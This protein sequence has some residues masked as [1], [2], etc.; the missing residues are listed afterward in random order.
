MPKRP[1]LTEFFAGALA[2]SMCESCEEPIPS[3]SLIDRR[4]ERPASES[5]GGPRGPDGETDTA[6]AEREMAAR[7]AGA[8]A[9]LELDRS[10]PPALV[11]FDKTKA[12]FELLKKEHAAH[13]ECA[14]WIART[15][16]N[17]GLELQ[18]VIP[19][20]APIDRGAMHGLVID[21]VV[22]HKRLKGTAR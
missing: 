2:L 4:A 3:A 20:V 21:M 6:R 13:P 11:V 14:E 17:Y 10:Q 12:V 5:E 7:V 15:L 16:A 9:D 18:E 8:V 22:F 19:R 1:L